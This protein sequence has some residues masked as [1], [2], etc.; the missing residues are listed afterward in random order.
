MW[1]EL[2]RLSLHRGF[3]RGD[4]CHPGFSLIRQWPSPKDASLKRSDCS[5]QDPFYELNLDVLIHLKLLRNTFPSKDSS[6]HK[7]SRY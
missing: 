4:F 5:I 6:L 2:A 7:A 3:L 1:N